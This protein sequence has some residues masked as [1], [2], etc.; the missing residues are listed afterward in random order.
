MLHDQA[1]KE[2]E[3]AVLA[4]AFAQVLNRGRLNSH[5]WGHWHMHP[6]RV[7]NKAV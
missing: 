6:A 2:R 1:R 4:A 3:S 7:D 5:P